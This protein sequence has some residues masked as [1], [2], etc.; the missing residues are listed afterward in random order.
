[1]AKPK[2]KR[3]S[4]PP[5]TPEPKKKQANTGGEFSGAKKRWDL[6]VLFF[7]IAIG[8]TYLAVWMNP[9][10]QIPEFTFNR[11]TVKIYPHDK[12]AYTQGLLFH[13]GF[14]YESTGLEGRSSIRKVDP[15]TGEV[16]QQHDL[17]KELFGEGLE[18][19]D[20][21]FIQL[22]WKNKIG[23]V[24]DDQFKELRRFN[25]D[26]EGWGLCFDGQKLI[27]SDGSSRL[28]F[29]D[30]ETFEE[31]GHL[32]VRRKDRRI[33]GR[34]NELEYFG[35]KIYANIY[36]SDKLYRIDAESGS[37][38]AIIDLGGLW[39]FKERPQRDAVINGIAI[40]PGSTGKMWVTGKLCP[41]MYEIEIVAKQQASN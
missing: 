30:P 13:D 28:R 16:L 24:Y 26:H 11:D 6:I 21:K 4:F 18:Q 8:G 2:K 38:E 37:V 29:L 14:L 33:L 22:T 12:D 17:A 7:V 1:M 10:N 15:T 40:K 35:S 20:G 39:P 36:D 31:I 9:R 23:I 34:L 41:N 27:V 3:K 5:P 25:Y 32:F 19:V